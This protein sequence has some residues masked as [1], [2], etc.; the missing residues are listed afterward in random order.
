MGFVRLN[1]VYGV[2]GAFIHINPRNFEL[3]EK[4]SFHYD[5]EQPKKVPKSIHCIISDIVRDGD[6]RAL[7]SLYCHISDIVRDGRFWS[8]STS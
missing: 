8:I 3:P 1:M 4:W 2:L 6:S 7:Q 5:V